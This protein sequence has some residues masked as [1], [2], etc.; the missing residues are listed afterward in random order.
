LRRVSLYLRQQ[1]RAISEAEGAIVLKQN[2]AEGQVSL[3]EALIYSGRSG[4][5]LAYFDRASV[6][7][8]YFPDIVL[9]FQALALCQ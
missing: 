1:D 7:N 2:F 5:A 8:P 6:L 9:H 4:E 3:G